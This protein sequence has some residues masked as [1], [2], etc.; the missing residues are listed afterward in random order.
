MKAGQAEETREILRPGLTIAGVGRRTPVSRPKSSPSHTFLMPSPKRGT[1]P[2]LARG[3]APETVEC[4][5][6]LPASAY[7]PPPL[8]RK[9]RRN[10][11][12][13]DLMFKLMC[14]Q[15]R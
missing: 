13:S 15:L 8:V 12:C 10:S 6:G 1:K 3:R 4:G 9:S 14:D 5:R 7:Q 2:G 11:A